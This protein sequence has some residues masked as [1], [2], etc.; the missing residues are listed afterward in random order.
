MADRNI[1]DVELLGSMSEDTNVLIEENGS[2]KKLN[3]KNEIDNKI[4]NAVNEINTKLDTLEEFTSQCQ[5]SSHILGLKAHKYG[6]ICIL[7]FDLSSTIG[8]GWI[9]SSQNAHIISPYMPLFD[10]PIIIG[11]VSTYSDN[12]KPIKLEYKTS[13]LLYGYMDTAL[14]SQITMQIIYFTA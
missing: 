1:C 11:G 3:L 4:N 14:S 12:S 5:I 10:T 8:S 2:L 7:N 9:G 6:K 13:G